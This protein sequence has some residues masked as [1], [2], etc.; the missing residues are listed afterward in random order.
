MNFKKVF[1]ILI[2]EFQKNKI[3][4]ALIGGHALSFAGVE[5]ST[6]DIDFAVLLE[7]SDIVDGI[8]KKYGYKV[9]HKTQ[10]VANYSS[11]FA[12]FGQVDFLFAHRKYALQMLK[13]AKP[14][15]I[16]GSK[17]KI[18]KPE[19]LI[20]LKIQSS[21]NDPQR[22]HKD[23]ADIES[24]IGANIKNLDLELVRE[25]FKLFEREKELDEIL[26]KVK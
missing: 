23:M 19:D 4:F 21:S 3:D 20:G 6:V 8:M 17:I 18:A 15:E 12:E 13:R 26:G 2:T 1:E 5:R 22:Y 24:V 14:E 7:K 16:F 11:P 10:D 9:F 25:Y